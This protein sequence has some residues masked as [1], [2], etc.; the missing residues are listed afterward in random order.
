MPDHDGA[1]SLLPFV[2]VAGVPPR[3]VYVEVR[4]R[5]IGAFK[6]HETTLAP[7]GSC[8]AQEPRSQLRPHSLGAPHA[9]LTPLP[10][11]H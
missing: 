11:A 3:E 10:H 4:G 1:T 2:D 8:V 5:L 9:S 6:V 7:V